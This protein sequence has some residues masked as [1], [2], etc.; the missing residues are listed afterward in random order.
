[1]TRPGYR[2]QVLRLQERAIDFSLVHSA[3]KGR[4]PTSFILS[5]FRWLSWKYS[6]RAVKLTTHLHLVLS[7]RMRGA[8][9]L[10]PDLPLWCEQGQLCL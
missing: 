5:E 4:G 10:L 9:P 1:M 2:L 7:L 3:Q 8:I 6:G